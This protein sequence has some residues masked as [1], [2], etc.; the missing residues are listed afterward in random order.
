M[1]TT[2]PSQQQDPQVVLTEL[3]DRIHAIR[4]SL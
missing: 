4:D 3:A 1:S 2:Q